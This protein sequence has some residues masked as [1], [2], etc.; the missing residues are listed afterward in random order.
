MKNKKISALVFV[1]LSTGWSQGAVLVNWDFSS[2]DWRTGQ[3]SGLALNDPS[4]NP[5][6]GSA[7]GNAAAGISVSDLTPS[8][9]LRVVVNATTGAGEADVRDFDFNGDG[10]NENYLEFT[11]TGDVPGSVNI[12]TI[13]ISQWRNG[14]G[15]VDGMAFEVSVDSGGFA[16][17]DQILVDSNAGN[18][19]SFDTFTFTEAISGADSVAIRFAPRNVNV[20]STGNIHINNIQVSGLVTPIP[21]PGSMA[22]IGLSGL[23]L[24][25]RR[26]N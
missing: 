1:A 10:V 18:G 24:L 6:L 4:P 16:L 14:A 22:L 13:S 8:A 25:R 3:G 12:E 20:G 17:Y 9:G 23:A 11:I 2:L 5:I 7:S 19:P 15:A 21:E 26:R